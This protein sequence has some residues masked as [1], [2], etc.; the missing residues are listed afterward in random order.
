MKALQ[1]SGN[2][3]DDLVYGLIDLLLILQPNLVIN[4]I[5]SPSFKLE[6][7][8]TTHPNA[9]LL[10]ADISGYTALAQALGAAGAHGTEM[11]SQS[12]D[13]FFGKSAL[14]KTTKRAAIHRYNST[15]TLSHTGIAISSVYRFNGDVIKFCGDAILCVFEPDRNGTPAQAALAAARCALE[16]KAK[17]RFFQA[18]EGVILD[19][20]QMLSHGDIIGN[21]G[22]PPPSPCSLRMHRVCAPF[23]HTCVR[24]PSGRQNAQPLRVPHHRRG[25]RPDRRD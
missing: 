12:L 7:H 8:F 21:Y 1:E 20:K 25:P 10:F 22:E 23:I 18:A 14:F 24:P 11:L 4:N 6:P 2:K 3:N 16:L 5:A 17:L 9:T 15:L 19:L 13:D